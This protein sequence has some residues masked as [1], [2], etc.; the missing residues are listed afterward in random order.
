MGEYAA[1][2]EFHQR[3]L[4]LAVE[5]NDRAGQQKAI[6]YHEKHLDISQQLYD[7]HGQGL[8][9]KTLGLG[10]Y[11]TAVECFKQYIDIVQQS[12]DRDEQTTAYL[13]VA[14]GFRCLD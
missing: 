9:Y 10:Q 6:E 3:E 7:W 4:D 14:D 13:S 5:H 1:A 8:S 11:A 12:G 2:I